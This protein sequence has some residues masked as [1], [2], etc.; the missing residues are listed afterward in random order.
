MKMNYNPT[1]FDICQ[2][3]MGLNTANS[4]GVDLIASK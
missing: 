3:E 2:E 4:K 1:T